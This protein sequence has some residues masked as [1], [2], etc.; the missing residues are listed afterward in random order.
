[1][2]LQAQPGGVLVVGDIMTDVIVKPDGPIARG[3]DC[4]AA[5]RILPGGSGANQATWLAH[6][7]LP[8]SLSLIHI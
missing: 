8:V 6:F 7:G 3:S 5:I 1:M 4:H 2:R